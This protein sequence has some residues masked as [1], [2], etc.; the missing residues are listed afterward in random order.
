[1]SYET[2]VTFVLLA[3]LA[4]GWA[5]GYVQC[6]TKYQTR[7]KDAQ[8]RADAAYRRYWNGERSEF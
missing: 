2:R 1:M 8:R 4:T 5:F 7:M 3:M 6:Y